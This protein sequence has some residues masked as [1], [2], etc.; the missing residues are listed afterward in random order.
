M[1]E[2]LT[3]AQMYQAERLAINIGHSGIEL[4]AAAGEAVVELILAN[5]TKQ[6]I[7]ILAG[8]GNTFF[9]AFPDP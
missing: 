4:M 7:L 3:T 1:T 5:Y 9:L 2:I 8:P 6:A